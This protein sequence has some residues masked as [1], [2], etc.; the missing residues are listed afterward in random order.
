LKSEVSGDLELRRSGGRPSDEVLKGRFERNK[1][2]HMKDLT[3]MEKSWNLKLNLG[4][5]LL[6]ELEEINKRQI[7]NGL[8]PIGT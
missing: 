2:R 8:Q 4:E 6:V 3:Q 5:A 7:E 1:Q